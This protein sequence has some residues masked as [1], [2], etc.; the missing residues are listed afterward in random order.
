V[1]RRQR[2]KRVPLQCLRQIIQK[3]L[4]EQCD[5][6]VTKRHSFL[7]SAARRESARAFRGLRA[8]HQVT[9]LTAD[10][11]WKNAYNAGTE[12]HG[13]AITFW[14][15][16]EKWRASHL[17]ADVMRYRT[18]SWNP[19]SSAI[20]GALQKFRYRAHFLGFTTCWVGVAALAVKEPGLRA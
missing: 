14:M 10:W 13:G 3:I 16:A 6:N 9:V 5:L 1:P 2:R 8:R 12:N 11:D 15:A 17:C 20:V 7:S 18:V 4:R 19:A